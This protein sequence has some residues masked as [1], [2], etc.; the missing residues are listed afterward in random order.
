[1]DVFLPATIF[2]TASRRRDRFLRR[3]SSSRNDISKHR[4]AGHP[5]RFGKRIPGMSRHRISRFVNR[6]FGPEIILRS[7][8]FQVNAW[9][10]NFQPTTLMTTVNGH[11][12]SLDPANFFPLSFSFLGEI[13]A[14]LG[15]GERKNQIQ[16]RFLESNRFG[17]RQ[18]LAAGKI[19]NLVPGYVWI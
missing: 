16:D 12:P 7:S 4:D 2:E 5:R 14:L 17:R 15:G 6:G 19:Y 9:N 3:E 8:S 13:Y 18:Q 10:A 11:W 1:M